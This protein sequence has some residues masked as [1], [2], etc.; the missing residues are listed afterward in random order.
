[1]IN[2]HLSRLV[3]NHDNRRVRRELTNVYELHRTVMS[4]SL[5]HI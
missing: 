1:M 5:I 2:V 3:L 4:L